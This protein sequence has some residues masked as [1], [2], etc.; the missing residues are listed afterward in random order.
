MFYIEHLQMF[1]LFNYKKKY[2]TI[3]DDHQANSFKDEIR[4]KKYS[5]LYQCRCQFRT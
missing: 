2:Y 1:M 5:E 3:A 4:H